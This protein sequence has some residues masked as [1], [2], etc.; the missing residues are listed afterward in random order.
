M[1]GPFQTESLCGLTFQPLHVCLLQLYH[2]LTQ[3]VHTEQTNQ[4]PLEVLGW[5]EQGPV[6]LKLTGRQASH[7]D[8][9]NGYSCD[10]FIAFANV[11]C[12]FALLDM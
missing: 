7:R 8:E 1:D 2:L 5:I 6:F 11:N 10:P 4:A 3:Q 9:G 12:A